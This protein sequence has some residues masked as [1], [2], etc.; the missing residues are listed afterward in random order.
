MQQNALE[1][2]GFGMETLMVDR[3]ESELYSLILEGDSQESKSHRY[4]PSVDD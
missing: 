3:M 1:I 2:A 4:S